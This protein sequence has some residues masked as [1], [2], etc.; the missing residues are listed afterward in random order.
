MTTDQKAK[1]R[2]TEDTEKLIKKTLENV[3]LKLL[4]LSRKNTLLNF[5][6]TKRSIRIIDELPT[7]TYKKLVVSGNGLEFLPADPPEEKDEEIKSLGEQK[8]LIITTSW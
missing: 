2:H 8:Q 5:R 6:E 1:T 7:E 3:R 4:D